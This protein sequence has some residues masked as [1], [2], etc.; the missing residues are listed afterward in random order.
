MTSYVRSSSLH[1]HLP[2]FP[3]TSS[4]SPVHSNGTR[5]HHFHIRRHIPVYVNLIPVGIPFS[6]LPNVMITIGLMKSQARAPRLTSS[7]SAIP[8]DVIYKCSSTPLVSQNTLPDVMVSI[9]LMTYVTRASA[10]FFPA[11]LNDVIIH[12]YPFD[13]ICTCQIL[14]PAY[15]GI[16][17][18]APSSPKSRNRHVHLARPGVV[19]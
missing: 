5:C 9:P 15:L 17:H 7:L 11:M 18:I 1:G 16:F 10:S 8:Q 3:L 14:L 12:S 4:L 19:A 2:P 13:V 6:T